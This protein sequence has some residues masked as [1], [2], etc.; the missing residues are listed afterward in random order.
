MP[1]EYCTIPP[2]PGQRAVVFAGTCDSEVGNVTG[3]WPDGF[4][5]P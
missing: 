5:S 1:S 3:R 2:M 4:T